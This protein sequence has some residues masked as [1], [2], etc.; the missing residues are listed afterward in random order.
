MEENKV[1][2]RNKHVDAI[3]L[4]ASLLIP[5]DFLP[6]GNIHSLDWSLV[7]TDATQS[8]RL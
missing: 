8:G 5:L 6:Q 1:L 3:G 4:K 7:A 2:N